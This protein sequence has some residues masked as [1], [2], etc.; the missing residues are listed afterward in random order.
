MNLPWQKKYAEYLVVEMLMVSNNHFEGF[1]DHKHV[2]YSL[3]TKGKGLV[4]T[5]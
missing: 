2:V 1:G 5:S 3:V 4:K